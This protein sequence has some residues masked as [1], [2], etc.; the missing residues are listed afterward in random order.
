MQDNVAQCGELMA[1][2]KVD[3]IVMDTPIMDYWMKTDPW[4]QTANL[5]LSPALATVLQ[6]ATQLP[7]F[8]DFSIEN[9]E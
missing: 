2:G 3:A 6:I 4:P 8:I 1:A 9:E 7:T 5:M